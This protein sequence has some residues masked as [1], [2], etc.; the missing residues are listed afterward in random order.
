LNVWWRDKPLSVPE[1]LLLGLL[2][3]AH[4]ESSFRPNP[5]SVAV[6]NAVHGSGDIGKA[7]AAAILTVGGRH[8][9]LEQT[10]YFLEHEYIAGQ[11]RSLLEANQKVPGWGGSF[12]KD[13]VDPLWVGVYDFLREWYPQIATKL[14]LVTIELHK[15][16]KIIYPN[17]SAF[18]AA[19]AIAL[20]VPAKL[21]VYLFISARLDAWAEIAW[22]QETEIEK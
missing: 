17:P 12:Q 15:Q 16:G 9:P 5:S 1:H 4:R 20:Q 10:Y 2:R 7:I 14:D 13:G 18:T 3:K 6:A 8:A 22:K 19:V 11:V 21:A